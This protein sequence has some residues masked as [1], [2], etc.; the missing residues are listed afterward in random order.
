[1][2][3]R[4]ERR[5]H[6]ARDGC[7]KVRTP[8]A[9][10]LQIRPQTG[11]ITIHCAQ[12]NQ[13]YITDRVEYYHTEARNTITLIPVLRQSGVTCKQRTATFSIDLKRRG[14]VR[15]STT[16]VPRRDLDTSAKT[17]LHGRATESE[18]L[19]LSDRQFYFHFCARA[20]S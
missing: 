17:R 9:R 6:C 16:S 10:P 4:S 1:M 7:R 12:C 11:P 8:P 13:T 15:W 2:K 3:K 5:K 18:Q 14:K 20:S 19:L